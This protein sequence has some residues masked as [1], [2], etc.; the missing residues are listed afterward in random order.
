MRTGDGAN[1]IS[2]RNQR[3]AKSQRNAQYAHLRP[4][5]DRRATGK[6]HQYES[7]DEFGNKLLYVPPLMTVI[8][9]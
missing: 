6:K 1:A 4:G 3:Q 5:D 7:A 8:A 9:R 2:R